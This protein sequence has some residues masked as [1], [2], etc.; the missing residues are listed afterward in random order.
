MENF[1]VIQL[2]IGKN[3]NVSLT[4]HAQ[5]TFLMTTQQVAEAFGIS[6]KT[7]RNNKRNNSDE[8]IESKHFICAQNMSAFGQ[9]P[10]QWTKRGI[11][12]LSMFVKSWQ[13]KQMRDWAE[14]VV[15]EALLSESHKRVVQPTR[16]ALPTVAKGIDAVG[17]QSEMIGLL[18]GNRVYSQPERR[19]FKK[20]NGV[21][22]ALKKGDYVP[23][24]SYTQGVI[25]FES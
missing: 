3:I 13:A 18:T 20:M 19:F 21:L 17:L 12:R 14:D 8:F 2:P 5:H 7:V 24:Q 10:T 16:A 1:S 4:P 15:F 6:D 25:A 9:A 23:K 22:E 11:I